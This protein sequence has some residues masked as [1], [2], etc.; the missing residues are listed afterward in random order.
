MED[1]RLIQYVRLH[2]AF[3][4][5]A[6]RLIPEL[7]NGDRKEQRLLLTQLQHEHRVVHKLA[8]EIGI[9]FQPWDCWI[10]HDYSQKVKIPPLEIKRILS[11]LGPLPNPQQD[12]NG[13]IQYLNYHGPLFLRLE[14]DY[15]SIFKD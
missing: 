6:N 2:S 9:N 4:S 11:R 3:K 5:L 7:K 8:Q 13:L 10:K 12:L 14:S 15:D 1:E